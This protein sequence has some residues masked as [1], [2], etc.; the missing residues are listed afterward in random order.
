MLVG[1]SKSAVFIAQ[2][3]NKQMS[4]RIHNAKELLV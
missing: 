1:R 4:Y 2:W 3:E